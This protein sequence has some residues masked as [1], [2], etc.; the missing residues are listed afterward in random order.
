VADLDAFSQARTR[1]LALA[2]SLALAL[3]LVHAPARSASAPPLFGPVAPLSATAALDAAVDGAPALATDGLGRWV[4]V[5]ESF[6]SLGGTIGTDRDVLFARSTDGGAT[7]SAPAPLDPG[8]AGDAAV[9]MEPAVAADGAGRFVA[10][11][12]SNNAALSGGRGADFDLFVARSTDGGASWSAPA[13][14]DP[15]AASDGGSE[16][17]AAVATDGLGTWVAL[18]QANA[19]L[20]GTLGADF[21]VLVARSTDGGASWSAPAPLHANAAADAGADATPRLA[22]DGAGAW[23]AVWS[24]RDSL[25]GTKGT[26]ADVLFVRSLDGGATWSA[27]SLVHANGAGDAGH[28]AEPQVV[29]DGAGGWV[30]AWQSSDTLGGTKGADNDIVVATSPDGAA[31]SAPMPIHPSAASDASSD[32]APSLASNG[33]GGLVAVWQANMALRGALGTDLDLLVAASADGGATWS[34]PA[35]AYPEAASDVGADQMPFVASDGAATWLLAWTSSDSLGG[36]IGTDPDPLVALAVDAP[37]CGD[38]VLHPLEA[39]DDGNVAPGDGCRTDC[40]VERC[41]DAVL[42]PQE[43]CDDGNADAGDGCRDDCSAEL[44]GDGVLDPQEA[45]DDGNLEPGDGCR[46]DCSAELCGDAVLDP[47]EACDDGNADAGDGCRG[48]CSAELCG[49]GVLDPSEACD[50]GN[51]APGD[52]CDAACA[53]EAPSPPGGGHGSLLD[54]FDA[55]VADGSL[56]GT[57]RGSS[58]SKRLRVLRR[59]LEAAERWLDDDRT[60][61]G[62][63]SLWVARLALDGAPNPPDLA[64][65]P[66]APLL[67]GRIDEAMEAGCRRPHPPRPHPRG[68]GHDPHDRDHPHEHHGPHG[69]CRH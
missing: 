64:T 16:G 45:C 50:D 54:A 32:T 26:D 35:A 55:A 47:Q 25:G 36:T 2:S 53:I 3:A 10:V 49:D 21:D 66:A 14:L 62:C 13:P 61:L 7:W 8:A 4:A 37:V 28:D 15:A 27:P 33:R 46:D 43:A 60:A 31:W 17:Q 63:G 12:R 11:W 38:G 42:D 44:C 59:I 56:V 67:A 20:G 40:T 52:G 69:D 19:A 34:A 24:S 22:A 51:A 58:A 57:G 68:D 18:W 6:D 30:V 1:L 9:D 41:G 23:V 39:C 29:H 5:W 48:D 65:G